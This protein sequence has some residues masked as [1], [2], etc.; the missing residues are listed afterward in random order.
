MEALVLALGLRMIR[1]PMGHPHPKLHQPDRKAGEGLR[2][3]VAPG[4]AIVHQ[5]DKWQPVTAKYRRQTL[6]NRHVPLIAAG[7][8]RQ[9]IARVVVNHR[10]RMATPPG[11]R[12]MA[13]EVH[14]P[15]LVGMR[16][17]KASIRP[18]MFGRS[19]LQLAMPTKN[20]RDR[21]LRR[22]SLQTVASHH[23]GDLASTPGAIALRPDA[24]NLRLHRL[25]GA[26]RTAVRAT[27]AV[28]KAGS[29]L[30]RIAP[31]PFV[32]VA[33]TDAEA[34]AEF[35][36]VGSRRQRQPHE[37][38]TLIHDRQLLP[39]HRCP[40]VRTSCF[41]QSVLDVSERCLRCL[42]SIHRGGSGACGI[43]YAIPLPF[44]GEGGC[45]RP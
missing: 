15:Q 9:G 2:A 5:H 8:H 23:L 32:A 26:L 19:L 3:A 11:H 6:P 22:N 12:E 29:P 20:F 37:L 43:A 41:G 7:V 28:G 16:P 34:A 38:F 44:P 13:F 25:F 27:R 17:L 39:R 30:R 35:F 24:Q 45:L 31:E 40:P 14:L 36:L 33:P 1:P 18:G 21:A 4:W 42:R 10:E